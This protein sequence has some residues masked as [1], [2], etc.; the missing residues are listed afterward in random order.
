[1][2]HLPLI[3]RL[4]SWSDQPSVD[5]PKGSWRLSLEVNQDCFFFPTYLCL[6][7]WCFICLLRILYTHPWAYL[8]VGRSLLNM[9]RYFC[10]LSSRLYVCPRS[11]CWSCLDRISSKPAAQRMP[12]DLFTPSW[13]FLLLSSCVGPPERWINPLFYLGLFPY[14]DRAGLF[15]LL[16]KAQGAC[17]LP[18]DL[19]L[20]SVFILASYLVQSLAGS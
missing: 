14:F 10:F 3:L 4:C 7:Y 13:E 5:L 15:S 12:W 1:M 2:P 17:F 18:W 20:E 9:A 16:R 19:V 11:L 6:A 8:H